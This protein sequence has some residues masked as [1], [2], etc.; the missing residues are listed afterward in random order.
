MNDTTQQGKQRAGR[1]VLAS[2]T[3]IF[4]TGFYVG[5]EGPEKFGENWR[6]I[7]LTNG[8]LALVN[9]D[10]VAFVELPKGN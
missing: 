9:L 4:F 10:H 7:L 1:I 3:E 5:P 6:G 2:G 8:D